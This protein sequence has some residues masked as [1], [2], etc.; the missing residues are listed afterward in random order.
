MYYKEIEI[1]GKTKR[2]KYDFNSIADIEEK[3]GAGIARLFSED[4]VGLHTIRLL[5]WGGLRHEDRG[6]T[7]QRAGLMVDQLMAEG[8]T[9][10]KLMEDIVEAVTKSG[11][12]GVIENPTQAKKK[13]S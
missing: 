2:L 11:I 1:D 7:I 3:S 5:L 6:L 4:M 8:Y 13:D 12:F 9:L 10:E